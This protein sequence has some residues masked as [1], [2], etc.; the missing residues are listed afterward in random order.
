MR[1]AAA[2]AEWATRRERGALPLIRLMVW[3]AL[4]VGRRTGRFLS[5][6]ACAYFYLFSPRSRA[7]SLAYLA[8]VLGRRPTAADRWRHYRCFATCLLDRVLLLNDR[9][10]LFDFTVYGEAA[11]T[12]IR[13]Q[14]GGCFLFGA[15]LGSFEVV[16]AASRHMSDVKTSLVM[17]EDNARKTNAVLNAINPA[18]AID[19]IGLGRPGSM[20]AV[21]DRL[22]DGHLVGILADRSL[23]SERRMVIPFLG[24]PA[25]FPVGPF[26]LAAIARTA[27]GADARLASRRPSL[28]HNLRDHFDNARGTSRAR[29]RCDAS[30]SGSN[31]TVAGRHT[32]GS[33]STISGHEHR[34]ITRSGPGCQ[35]SSLPRSLV[36]APHL[37]RRRHPASGN[38]VGI[39][40]AHGQHA[41]VRTASAR[42][43][44]KKFVQLLARP[45]QSS[46][47]LIFN[48]PDR[49]QK[50]TLAPTASRLTV[51][52]DRLTVVQPDGKTRDVSLSEVPEIG[53][54][55]ESIR[56]TLAGDGATLTRYY[57]PTLSG[58]AGNWSLTLE[59]RDSRLRNLV[60]TIRMQGEGTVIRSIETV[61]RDGDRTEMT[62]TPD[63]R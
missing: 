60:T 55:V 59:P 46:G 24:A 15:H 36:I 8:R 25:C 51:N 28:R 49:L 17:Y 61:E 5:L 14:H 52:G 48:A 21:K 19:I 53:A 18:M 22:D 34:R 26:R 13:E 23:E 35:G 32:I 41:G 16:R 4:R 27:S 57:T 56:A 10:E 44:E 62:I 38:G 37:C 63:P 1:G 39:A 40:A 9:V 12:A 3:I 29:R 50:E 7:A 43:V 33:T 11:L 6:P 20:L 2:Q 58:T 54:L 31:I 42:F 47:T 30:S 45:L